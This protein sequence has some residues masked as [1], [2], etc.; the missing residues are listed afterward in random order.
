VVIAGKHLPGI[1]LHPN[2]EDAS[3]P[4]AFEIENAIREIVQEVP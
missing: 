4:Q 1:G 3:V 2:L